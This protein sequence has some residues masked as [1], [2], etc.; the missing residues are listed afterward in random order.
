MVYYDLARLCRIILKFE[1]IL[2]GRL[3]E[4]GP[5]IQEVAYAGNKLVEQGY[6]AHKEK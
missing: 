3:L 6:G 4:E 1:P 5:G 2:F